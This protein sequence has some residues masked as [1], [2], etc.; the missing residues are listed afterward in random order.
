MVKEWKLVRSTQGPSYKV[1]S[2]RTDT[3]KSPLTSLEHDFYVIESPPWVNINE[4]SPGLIREYT[5]SENFRPV[6]PASL[7]PQ[8]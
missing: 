2:V 3:S 8:H 1:F 6:W 5:Q 4:P 7:F